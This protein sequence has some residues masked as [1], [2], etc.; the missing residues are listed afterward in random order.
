LIGASRAYG[1]AV[2]ILLAA[3]MLAACA[4]EIRREAGRPVA[5]GRD[6]HIVRSGETVY[7]IA[8]R[9]GLDYRDLAQWN[10]LG[11]G[12]LI[13][14]GQRLRL[15]PSVSTKGTPEAADAERLPPPTRWQWPSAGEIEAAFGRSPRTASGILIGGELG[16]PVRAG[17]TARSSTRE[18]GS[19]VTDSC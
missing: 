12:S 5:G 3:L 6:Y 8:G 13:Y 2:V 15:G 18:A 14:P 7:G 4:G 10:R 9:Y 17:P 16:Q 1:I 19:R 11:D